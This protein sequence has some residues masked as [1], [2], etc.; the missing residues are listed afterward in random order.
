MEISVVM[1]TYEHPRWLEKVL[2]G[3][4]VQTHGGFEVVVAD[5]GSGP[6]TRQVVDRVRR[7][8]KLEIRHVWHEDNGFRKCTILNKGVGAS[9]GDYLVFTD[10]DCIPAPDFLE[11]HARLAEPE[12]FLSGGYVKL[13]MSLS[14]AITRDDILSGRATDAGWLVRNGMPRSRRLL[15]LTRSELAG[16]LLDALSPTRASWNGHNASTWKK[17]IIATNGF[18][19]RMRYGGQDREFGERLENMGIR[20]KRIRHR[21]ACVHLDHARGY[22]RP[23]SIARNRE[24]RAHTR[25]AGVERTPYG[26]VWEEGKRPDEL[27]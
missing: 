18:D 20:G 2:W 27:R 5:D 25:S 13:P 3:F 21:A 12:R 14:R 9:A 4:S 19:E 16:L 23:E 22:A 24:I 26:I 8:T 15:K 1:S 11:W 6:E 7:E 10:A 17:H